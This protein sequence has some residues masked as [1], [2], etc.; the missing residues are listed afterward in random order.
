MSGIG[1]S[2]GPGPGGEREGGD[3]YK[4]GSR[5]EKSSISGFGG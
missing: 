1:K 2:L 5:R 4:S 3:G